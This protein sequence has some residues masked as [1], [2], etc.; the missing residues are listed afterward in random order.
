MFVNGL[1]TG[2]ISGNFP[3][4]LEALTSKSLPSWMI[5][6]L[7]L[8]LFRIFDQTSGQ[9]IQPRSQNSPKQILYL[10]LQKN[11]SNTSLM[12]KCLVVLSNIWTWNCF[13]VSNIG[14]SG[15]ESHL[16]LPVDSCT[17][18]VFDTQSTKRH[19]ITTVM[20]ARMWLIIDKMNSYLQCKCIDSA[21]LNMRWE[22]L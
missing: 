5:P 7:L 11:I 17:N 9:L 12:K 2:W 22:M 13:H 1:R 6:P 20:N 21:L 4:L 19:C 14:V 16:K 3:H 8:N 10:W 18:T 15:R